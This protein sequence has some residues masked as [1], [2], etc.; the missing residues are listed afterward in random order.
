MPTWAQHEISEF[1]KHFP[2]RVRV[3]GKQGHRSQ[4]LR[5]I[6]KIISR[7]HSLPALGPFLRRRHTRPAWGYIKNR[8][9]VPGHRDMK[10]SRAL[11]VEEFT[12]VDAGNR[13][14]Y[15]LQRAICRVSSQPSSSQALPPLL[16]H[17]VREGSS[18]VA[19]AYF[20]TLTR[21]SSALVEPWKD[22]L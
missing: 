16:S 6:G 19:S 5:S 17:A 9:G 22:L 2:D 20:M 15:V 12:A 3:W 11:R 4:Y 18:N 13:P 10:C 21:L 14:I 1:W 7:D 8:A